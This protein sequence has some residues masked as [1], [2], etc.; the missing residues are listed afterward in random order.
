MTYNEKEILDNDKQIEQPQKTITNKLRAM[1]D[2]RGVNW[3]YGIT[4]F[5][6]TRFNVNG[7]DLTFTPMRGGFAY[8]TI[9]TPEQ[10]I[11]TILGTGTCHMRLV[12]EEEDADGFV[13]PDYYK[14][15][16]GPMW[17]GLWPVMILKFSRDI[18]LTV[19]R[20]WLSN[21]EKWCSIY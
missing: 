1:L 3:D 13:W 4:G 2:E 6:T 19:E 21:A 9:L 12:Y 8:S 10:A 5:T 15:D 17:T 20:K 16:A 11:E 14:C 18:V 7:I